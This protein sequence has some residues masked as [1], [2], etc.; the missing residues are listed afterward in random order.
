MPEKCNKLDRIKQ[1]ALMAQFPQGLTDEEEQQV[2]GCFDHHL[3]YHRLKG[4]RRLFLCTSCGDCWEAGPKDILQYSSKSHNEVD[5]CPRCHARVTLKAVGKLRGCQHYQSLHEEHNVV[6]FRAARDGALMVSAGR[7]IV[8]YVP[9]ELSGWPDENEHIFPVPTL[10]FSER[11]RYWMKRGELASWKTEPNRLKDKTLECWQTV[12]SDRFFCWSARVSAGEPNPVDSC[13]YR[14]PDGGA[15]KVIG[16][17]VL[18]DTDLRYSAVEQYFDIER[19][20][21]RGVVSYLA[22]YTKRPQ[23]EFLVKLGHIDVVDRLIRDDDLSG[24][25]VNWRAKTPPAFF[26]LSK[27]TYRIWNDEGGQLHQL[28]LYKSLPSGT[29]MEQFLKI[30]GVQSI[31]ADTLRKVCRQAEQWHIPILS[32]LNY[33]KG[34]TKAQLWLDYVNMGSKL[35]L[36]FSQK[37]VLLPKDLTAR[38]DSCME[39]VEYIENQ[40]TLQ[41]YERRRKELYKK[42]A[43][44]YAG[45]LIRIPGSASEIHREGRILR[46]CV[47]GY[48]A[49]HMEGKVTILFLRSVEEPDTP[50]CTIE[51]NGN[52]LVQIH[53]YQNDRGLENPRTL[54]K[55][56][57]NMWLPWVGTGSPRDQQG[58]PI[59]QTQKNEE[60]KTA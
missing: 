10:A 19:P 1:A 28:E 33:L 41:K 9:G 4:K 26:G 57:L 6:I 20:L 13:M 14:Q 46:H 3:F 27:Q 37:D 5:H 48:A 44:E 52:Q 11:R 32:L 54:Y 39:Q 55:E 2:I 15:Y 51:M 47:G 7:A 42:Y 43:V 24:K 25:L 60:V 29:A 36:D 16:W 12:G 45:Y 31:H 30:P 18:A 56:F 50:L 49:R 21:F 23:L 58:R 22:R 35:K 59:L 38:H 34:Q 8:D 53:G 40:E 17:D